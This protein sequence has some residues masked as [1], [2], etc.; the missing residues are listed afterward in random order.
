MRRWPGR[1]VYALLGIP[2]AA[3]DHAGGDQVL[4]GGLGNRTLE[5]VSD[6]TASAVAIV[7][8]PASAAPVVAGAASC[9]CRRRNRYRLHGSRWRLADRLLYRGGRCRAR[10]TWGR[11][12]QW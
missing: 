4:I 8:S 3:T 10:S 11:F 1:F 6:C 9:R 5:A 2:S 12:P 7:A